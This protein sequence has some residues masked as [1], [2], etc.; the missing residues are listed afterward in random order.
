MHPTRPLTRALGVLAAVLAPA[1]V[2]AQA[3]AAGAAE[4]STVTVVHGIPGQD[5]GLDPELPVDV[6][7]NGELCALTD[8]RFGDVSDRLELPEGTYDLEVKLSDG[9]CGGATA[10]SADDVVLPGGVDASVVANLDAGGEP[11]L[12]VFVNDL[13]PT[14]RYQARVA[15]HHLAAAPAVDVDLTRT[16]EGGRWSNPFVRLD[17]VV[18]GDVGVADTWVGPYEATVTPTGGDEPVLTADLVLIGGRAYQVYA[19]GSVANG[20]LTLIVDTQLTDGA[21]D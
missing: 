14:E 6:L 9:D 2:L 15:V 3:P 11:T 19:V 17:G 13:S 1:A 12:S 5:L 16:F 21:S 4:T 18:N 10:I 8:F 20:T 7:V